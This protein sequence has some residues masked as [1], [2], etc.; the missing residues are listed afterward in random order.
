MISRLILTSFSFFCSIK[1]STV[2][3]YLH[4][5]A[6]SHISPH[7]LLNQIGI[8]SRSNTEL[9]N[10]GDFDPEDLIDLPAAF[11]CP[12]V[13]SCGDPVNLHLLPN[14]HFNSPCPLVQQV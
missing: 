4:D 2:G 8:S 5:K 3:M 13:G 1:L 6:L 14:S 10:P 11:R 9:C 12:V 7:V